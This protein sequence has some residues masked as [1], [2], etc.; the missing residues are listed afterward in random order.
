MHMQITCTSHV[1]Q[2]GTLVYA[3]LTVANKDITC[4]S[5]VHQVGTLVYARLTVA[6][7]DM[8]PEALHRNELKNSYPAL[9]QNELK[10]QVSGT[11]SK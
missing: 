7:K 9:F 10:R 11:L 2:V 1:H 4:I 5:H 6:N 8:D 3:R